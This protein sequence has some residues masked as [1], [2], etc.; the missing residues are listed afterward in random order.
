MLKFNELEKGIKLLAPPVKTF[1][2]IKD[3]IQ[4]GDL[5]LMQGIKGQSPELRKKTHCPYSHVGM[6]IRDEAGKLLFL[7]STDILLEDSA[8]DIISNS[9]HSGVQLGYLEEVLTLYTERKYGTYFWRS[10]NLK[11]T[12]EMTDKALTLADCVDGL[13]FELDN[14]LKYWEEG[15]SGVNTGYD[16]FFCSQLI[17]YTYEYLSLLTDKPPPNAYAP[18]DFSTY[19]E[20]P[21]TLLSG[22]KLAGKEIQITI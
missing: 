5:F 2:D 19:R 10:L 20:S 17:A 21:L 15:Q 16:T 7:Q 22:A 14:M 3:E 8:T 1:N 13:P 9:K 11:R 12:P 4:T 6:V 18:K